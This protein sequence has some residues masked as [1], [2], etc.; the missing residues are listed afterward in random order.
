MVEVTINASSRGMKNQMRIH[1]P[2]AVRPCQRVKRLWIRVVVA[3]YRFGTLAGLRNTGD[4]PESRYVPRG[5]PGQ[6]VVLSR[7]LLHEIAL[8]YVQYV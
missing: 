6:A 4:K 2:V 8:W 1:E 5:R 7:V 3:P